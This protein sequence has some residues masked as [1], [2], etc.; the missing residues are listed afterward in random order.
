MSHVHPEAN[1]LVYLNENRNFLEIIKSGSPIKPFSVQLRSRNSLYGV[2]SSARPREYLAC[3]LIYRLQRWRPVAFG[4]L[5]ISCLGYFSIRSVTVFSKLNAKQTNPGT[6]NTILIPPFATLIRR[7]EKV[8]PS[9]SLEGGMKGREQMA[10]EFAFTLRNRP[11]CVKSSL[12]G[13]WPAHRRSRHRERG[14]T[15]L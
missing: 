5:G 4:W 14:K 8:S 3:Y 1:L 6:R 9:I 2:E 11:A 7:P 12:A 10:A 13:E 15:R